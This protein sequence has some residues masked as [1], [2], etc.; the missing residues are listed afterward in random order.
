MLVL[1]YVFWIA[2]LTAS[3]TLASNATP[4]RVQVTLHRAAGK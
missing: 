1:F 2:V 4:R 3:L